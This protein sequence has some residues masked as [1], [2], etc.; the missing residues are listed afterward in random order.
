[1]PNGCG[2]IPEWYSACGD[3]AIRAACEWY[4]HHGCDSDGAED[5]NPDAVTPGRMNG[6]MLRT[7]EGIITTPAAML[8]E[9]CGSMGAS[10]SCSPLGCA[11]GYSMPYWP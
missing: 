6:A 5:S 10:R 7:G 2:Y 3:W 8:A 9:C 4:C 1:M 11:M